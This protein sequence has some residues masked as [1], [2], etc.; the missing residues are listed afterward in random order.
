MN[1]NLNKTSLHLSLMLL[2]C[3]FI[4]FV[5]YIM[6]S[7]INILINRTAYIIVTL[8][9]SYFWLSLFVG[10]FVKGITHKLIDKLLWKR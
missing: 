5:V 3:S 4:Y 7:E 8:A 10:L 1:C 9:Y 2:H 6:Y